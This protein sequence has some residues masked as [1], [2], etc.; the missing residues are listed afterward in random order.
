M[1]GGG[2]CYFFLLFWSSIFFHL[3]FWLQTNDRIFMM[4]GMLKAFNWS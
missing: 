4:H 3:I 2:E 1:G